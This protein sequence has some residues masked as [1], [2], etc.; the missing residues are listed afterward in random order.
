MT[1]PEKDFT[2][3]VLLTVGSLP[4]ISFL[5][6]ACGGF[7]GSTI[8]NTSKTKVKRIAASGEEAAPQSDGDEVGNVGNDT[9]ACDIMA[10]NY[11]PDLSGI[12]DA[13]A[14]F[15]PKV[16]MY[17]EY[18]SALLGIYFDQYTHT[19][20]LKISGFSLL[21]DGGEIV[22]SYHVSSADLMQDPTKLYPMMINCIRLNEG[23]GMTMLILMSNNKSCKLKIPKENLMPEVKYKGIDVVHLTSKAVPANYA[24]NLLIGDANKVQPMANIKSYSDS[25]VYIGFAEPPTPALKAKYTFG[26]RTLRTMQKD[27]AFRASSGGNAAGNGLNGFE[28]TD[29]MGNLISLTDFD[30]VTGTAQKIP[31]FSQYP[32]F[33]CYKLKGGKYYRTIITVG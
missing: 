24:D 31:N 11:K 29:I 13:P 1:A 22:A 7:N 32:T 5:V 3:R 23:E 15:I 27:A 6:Q 2:R 8:F 33:V 30:A 25:G 19:A 21:R 10:V 12:E 20:P 17:G 9:I 26:S 14:S 16:K 18:K 4:L 28:M